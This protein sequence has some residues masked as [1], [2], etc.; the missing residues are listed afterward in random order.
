MVDAKYPFSRTA[1]QEKF[2]VAYI[3]AV[4]AAAGYSVS[5][6]EIDEDSIDIRIAQKSKGAKD[7][8]GYDI[9]SAQVKCTSQADDK[10]KS[11]GF[12]HF[13]LTKKNYNELGCK[14][15]IPRI[16]IVL[17]V[18]HKEESTWLEEMDDSMILRH[19]AHWI[20][21]RGNEPLGEDA[22]SRTVLIPISQRIDVNGLRELMN[23]IAQGGMP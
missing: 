4:A 2:S 5:I 21:L 15:G 9:L 1:R 17:Y 13:S 16:L 20:S 3:R 7:F 19:T 12:I 10:P 8:S 22:D 6:D 11:D 18:P 14:T 23:K